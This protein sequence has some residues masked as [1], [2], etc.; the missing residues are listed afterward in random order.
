MITFGEDRT[1]SILAQLSRE[2]PSTTYGDIST[3]LNLSAL[4]QMSGSGRP[5][6]KIE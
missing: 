5:E 3:T 2:Q 1:K 6:N 4:G